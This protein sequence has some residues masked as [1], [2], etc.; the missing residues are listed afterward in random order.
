MSENRVMRRLAPVVVSLPIVSLGLLLVTFAIWRAP[1][2]SD[3]ELY[4]H[5][6]SHFERIK[7]KTI[8]VPP[9]KADYKTTM[10]HMRRV[11]DGAILVGL[12]ICYLSVA[13][14]LWLNEPRALWVLMGISVAGILYGADVG[15]HPGPILTVGGF[16][17]ILFGASLSWA[18]QRA[19]TE[20]LHGTHS[21]A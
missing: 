17:L 12:L 16:S 1:W 8:Y 2:P 21:A 11:F 15:L 9:E 3:P 18:S 6:I 7:G 4:G 19:V 5:H 13:L 10:W 14:A 20:K